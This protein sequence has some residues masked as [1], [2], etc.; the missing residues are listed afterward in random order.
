MRERAQDWSRADVEDSRCCR[1]RQLIIPQRMKRWQCRWRCNDD[2]RRW[3]DGTD[4]TREHDSDEMRWTGEMDG[5][6]EAEDGDG[7]GDEDVKM[8]VGCSC[9]C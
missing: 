9:C 6:D 8:V 1:R 3:R 2:E 5:D 4:S 7:D